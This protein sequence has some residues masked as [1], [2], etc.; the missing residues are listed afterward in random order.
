MILNFKTYD[1]SLGIEAL[2]CA[3]SAYEFSLHSKNKIIICPQ[4]VDLENV[5]QHYPQS[6]NF[7]IWSQ[8]VDYQQGGANT[9]FL[10]LETLKKIGVRG[11]LINHAEHK[12]SD[13]YKYNKIDDEI[14]LC[15]CAADLLELKLDVQKNTEFT[16]KYIAYEPPSLIGGNVSVSQSHGDDI[17]SIVDN[18]PSYDI[19]VGAGVKTK[20]DVEMAIKYGAKGILIASGF[21]YAVDKSDFLQKLLEY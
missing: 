4:T 1:E 13:I 11:S 3:R 8:H 19:L 12:I 5:I 21:V 18:F 9:G 7:E 14:N 10:T 20:K 6:D 17:E 16:P 2:R 15:L